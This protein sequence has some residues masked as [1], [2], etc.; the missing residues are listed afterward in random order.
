VFNGKSTVYEALSAVTG[1]VAAEAMPTGG[2]LSVRYEGKRTVATQ[3]FTEANI[4]RDS[5][6]LSYSLDKIGDF[7]GYQVEYRN[8]DDWQP[9]YV[10]WPNTAD[11]GPRDAL[12]PQ[13]VSLFGCTSRTH[14]LDYA[15]YLWNKKTRLRRRVSFST[16]LEGLIVMPGDKIKVQHTLADY[17][18][19]GQVLDWDVTT[20]T[21]TVDADVTFKTGAH[22]V[23]LRAEDGTPGAPIG[24]TAGAESN[25]LVLASMPSDPV[26]TARQGQTTHWAFGPG[27]LQTREYIVDTVTPEAGV[28]VGIEATAYD[29]TVFALTGPLAFLNSEP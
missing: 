5:L 9:A 29:D 8:P 13:P 21:L 12:D 7:N 6:A 20:R 2:S 11:G 10:I 3:L 16:E 26:Y 4:V 25:E 15:K 28:E 1:P 18:Q 22:F 27:A 23:L 24:V 19:G 17:G 14:A